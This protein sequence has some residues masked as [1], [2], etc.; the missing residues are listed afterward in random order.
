MKGRE[1]VVRKCRARGSRQ[2]PSGGPVDRRPFLL[3][4]LVQYVVRYDGPHA[5]I[6]ISRQEELPASAN[7]SAAAST[8]TIPNTK[9]SIQ[10]DLRVFHTGL[11]TGRIP[12]DHLPS[13]DLASLFA[14]ILCS[15]LHT[16]AA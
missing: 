8:A 16:H 10:K 9:D 12:F 6:A 14:I 5:L 1:G 2:P 13:I 7:Q 3:L 4:C 11:I 15:Y